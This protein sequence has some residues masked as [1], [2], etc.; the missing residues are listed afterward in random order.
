MTNCIVGSQRLIK[1]ARMATGSS[2]PPM[3]AQCNRHA[4]ALVAIVGCGG[5]VACSHVRKKWE[6][7]IVNFGCACGCNNRFSSEELSRPYMRQLL[8]LATRQHDLCVLCHDCLCTASKPTDSAQCSRSMC[9]IVELECHVL[10]LSYNPGTPN[11]MM[12]LWS[13]T[14]TLCAVCARGMH[15]VAFVCL[16]VCDQKHPF[17]HLLVKYFCKNGAHCS[18]IHQGC[19]QDLVSHTE[20][21]IPHDSVHIIVSLRVP[22]WGKPWEK[23]L[24]E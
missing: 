15:S 19:L 11:S 1:L 22:L 12:I 5:I 7:F 14:I 3:H 20:I 18:L 8:S 10:C 17:T 21:A 6:W 13:T 9:V 4:R 16:C 23:Q 24:F 2:N